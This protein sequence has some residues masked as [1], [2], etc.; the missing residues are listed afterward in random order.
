LNP[1]VSIGAEPAPQRVISL[2]PSV[3]EILFGI[4]V[5]NQ[6]VGVTDFCNYPEAAKKIPRVGGFINP[7]M[8]VL[9]SLQPDLLIVQDSA[10]H[11]ETQTQALGIPTLSLQLGSVQAILDSILQLGRV[12]NAQNRAQAL[13]DRIAHG[14]EFYRAKLKNHPPKPVFLVFA[15]SSGDAND[16]FAVGKG[17]FLDDLLTLAGGKNILPETSAPYPKISTEFVIRQSP[18]IIIELLP[19]NRG[20][21]TETRVRKRWEGFSSIPAVRDKNIHFLIADYMTIPGPRILNIIDNFA[22]AIHPDVFANTPPY[23]VPEGKIVHP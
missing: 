18:Q 15:E 4:G 17:A 16:L 19:G 14:I 20:I 9:L 5:E 3:T 23:I 1:P 6:V 7:N 21:E 12:M 8:E 11:I 22:R 10:R 2:S 13:H